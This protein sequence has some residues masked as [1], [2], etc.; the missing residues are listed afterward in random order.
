MN[1]LPLLILIFLCGCATKT[2]FPQNS[3]SF[4]ICPDSICDSIVIDTL[5]V[6]EMW[7]ETTI[8]EVT[9]IPIIFEGDT[10]LCDVYKLHTVQR[11]I[12]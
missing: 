12:Y 4:N 5:C 3:D 8:K 7:E 6:L 9:I 10:F 2:E 11:R 1:K